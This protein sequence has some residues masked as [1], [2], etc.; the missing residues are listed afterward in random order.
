MGGGRDVRGRPLFDL[1]A[2]KAFEGSCR[3]RALS[4]R[5]MRLRLHSLNLYSY[6]HSAI[7]CPCLWQ[8]KHTSSVLGKRH[9]VVP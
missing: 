2:T 9:N 3:D 6:P 8:R 5:E 7:L 4:D 1:R